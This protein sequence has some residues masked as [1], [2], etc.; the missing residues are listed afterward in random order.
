MIPANPNL[1]TSVSSVLAGLLINSTGI[2]EQ[3]RETVVKPAIRKSLSKSYTNK[4][5][6]VASSLDMWGSASESIVVNIS[7]DDQV[8]VRAEGT[9]EDVYAAS[10]LEYGTPDRPPR[11]VMRQFSVTLSDDFKQAMRDLEE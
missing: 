5:R 2:K 11:A 9:D 8:S 10:L 7:D 4:V 6:A 3:I 1:T